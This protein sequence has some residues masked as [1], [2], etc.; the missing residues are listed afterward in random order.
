VTAIT[1]TSIYQRQLW[2]QN[3]TNTPADW[4]GWSTAQ[5]MIRQDLRLPAGGGSRWNYR[6]LSQ[7]TDSI[8]SAETIRL[9]N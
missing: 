3:M 7:K 8:V 5:E 1:K 6:H 2:L 9:P 4:M